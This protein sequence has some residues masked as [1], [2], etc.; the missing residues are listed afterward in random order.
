MPSPLQEAAVESIEV[1]AFAKEIPDLI[2]EFDTLYSFAKK[3]FKTVP[4][5]NITEGGGTTRASA[6]VPFRAQGGAPLTQ[7]TGDGDGIGRGSGSLWKSF[8]LSPVVIKAANEITWLAKKAT[9]GKDRG[10]F[11]VSAQELKN[12]LAACTRG[13]EGL[14]NGDG[15]GAV[16]QIP[17]TATVSSSSGSGNQTSFISGLNNVAGFTDQQVISV[18]PSVGGTTRGTATISLVDPVTN[19]LWFSTALPSTGGATATG[20]FLM[21]SGGAATGAAGSSV[22][23]LRFWQNNGN[24][25]TIAGVNRALYPGRLSTPT[26]NLAGAPVTQSVGLRAATLMGRALGPDADSIKNAIWYTGPDQG[27]AVSNLMFNV[28]VVN[29]QDVKGDTPIDMGKKFFPA[30]YCNRELKISWTAKPGRLDLFTPDTWYIF[31]TSPLELYDFG[32]GS[33]VMPVPDVAGS[34]SYLTS[35]IMAYI[36]A[37]NVCNS[38]MIAGAFVQNAAQP[39]I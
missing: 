37:F 32:G 3:N 35:Y 10:L 1:D 30:T 25:G 22:L 16:D 13:I 17:S 7:G 24:T 26:I 2:P 36:T 23:G 39:A 9:E 27:M 15:S 31:E 5:S 38:N 21:V 19:T 14:M 20:D 6:R 8:A 11:N 12:S 29:A 28:Q 18:F 34:G 33:T 4:T